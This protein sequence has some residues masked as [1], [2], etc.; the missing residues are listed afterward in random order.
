MA[1]R[2]QVTGSSGKSSKII[3]K[4]GPVPAPDAAPDVAPAEVKVDLEAE[5]VTPAPPVDMTPESDP[6]TDPGHLD[7]RHVIEAEVVGTVVEIEIG[8][9][10]DLGG[11]DMSAESF[12]SVLARLSSDPAEV[13]APESSIQEASPEVLEA[14][15]ADHVAITVAAPTV[16]PVVDKCPVCGY[17]YGVQM[18]DEPVA[19]VCSDCV[20]R[21]E[22]AAAKGRQPSAPPA[23]EPPR[24]QRSPEPDNWLGASFI[25]SELVFAYDR[26]HHSSSSICAEMASVAYTWARARWKPE[27]WWSGSAASISSS[28][29]WR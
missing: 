24:T 15:E 5:V 20:K 21:A 1:A 17:V 26:L 28:A 27:L 18:S 10:L 14:L 8:E 2:R 29:A 12:D 7:L 22:I 25:C 19:G 13:P 3:K 11:V 16:G 23:P 6:A 9:P 4:E